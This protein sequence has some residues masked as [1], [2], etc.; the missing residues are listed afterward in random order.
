MTEKTKPDACE[1]CGK[2]PVTDTIPVFDTIK[3]VCTK[4]YNDSVDEED[5]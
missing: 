2:K 5:E 3:W 4:C 1:I